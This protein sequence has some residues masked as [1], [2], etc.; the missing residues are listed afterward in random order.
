MKCSLLQTLLSNTS[1]YNQP[2]KQKHQNNIERTLDYLSEEVKDPVSPGRLL[3]FKIHFRILLQR[4]SHLIRNLSSPPTI[5][6]IKP[7][8]ELPDIPV[9]RSPQASGI[10]HVVNLVFAKIFHLKHMANVFGIIKRQTHPVG[11]ILGE[12]VKADID[13]DV[14]NAVGAQGGG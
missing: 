10:D 4:V 6:K 2:T 12:I 3:G 13:L 8:H 7:L 11:D 14:R 5:L 9:T 1:N